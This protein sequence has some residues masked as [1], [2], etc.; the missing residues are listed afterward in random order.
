[1]TDV[2]ATRSKTLNLPSFFDCWHGV[3]Q[4]DGEIENARVLCTVN[5]TFRVLCQYPSALQLHTAQHVFAFFYK[6][7]TKQLRVLE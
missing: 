5:I 4:T 1:M 2:A 6:I 3:I 7:Q